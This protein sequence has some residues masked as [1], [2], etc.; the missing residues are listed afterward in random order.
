MANAG[1]TTEAQ[2]A[3]REA[4][5]AEK[6]RVHLISA[7]LVSVLSLCSLC[8]CGESS[9][10]EFRVSDAR[11]QPGQTEAPVPAHVRG[12][13]ADVRGVPRAQPPRRG[14]PA[15]PTLRLGVAGDAA[16]VQARAEGRA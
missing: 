4:A 7:F 6:S 11:V 16:G 8:L 2:R 1:F 10:S 14:Q 3:Q 5:N 9:E 13:V 12:L 15:R